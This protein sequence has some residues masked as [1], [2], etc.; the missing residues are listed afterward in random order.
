MLGHETRPLD[1][2]LRTAIDGG[3]LA[4]EFRIDVIGAHGAHHRVV[5][6]VTAGFYS[7][8]PEAEENEC[9]V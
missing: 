1:I 9:G 8:D 2:Y 3:G 5:P 6:D 4:T 7:T